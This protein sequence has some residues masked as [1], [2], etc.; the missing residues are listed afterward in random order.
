MLLIYRVKTASLMREFHE[1]RAFPSY[2]TLIFMFCSAGDY[3]T[4]SFFISTFTDLI[5]A[6][7]C[8]KWLMKCCAINELMNPMSQRHSVEVLYLEE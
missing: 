4:D 5:S 8:P 1:F 2:P 3:T 7:L 6:V